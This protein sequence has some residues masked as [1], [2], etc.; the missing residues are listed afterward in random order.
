MSVM[1]ARGS[2]EAMP[3]NGTTR[4]G[5]GTGTIAVLCIGS[6][7]AEWVKLDVKLKKKKQ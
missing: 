1:R 5:V 4:N 7:V 2:A 3:I 6:G